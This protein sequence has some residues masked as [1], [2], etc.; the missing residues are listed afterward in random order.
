MLN[1]MEEFLNNINI[2][3]KQARFALIGDG[4]TKEE[5]LKL[6]DDQVSEIWCDRFKLQIMDNFYKGVQVGLYT[7]SEVH[8]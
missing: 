7:A 8:E 2:D 1:T 3:K 5:A 6:T 4:Y